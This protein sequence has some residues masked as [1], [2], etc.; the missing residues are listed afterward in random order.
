M[1]KFDADPA[2][3]FRTAEDIFVR[4]KSELAMSKCVTRSVW[5]WQPHRDI[6]PA[7]LTLGCLFSAAGDS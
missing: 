5:C 6:N 4:T 7:P 2:D 3:V 1:N